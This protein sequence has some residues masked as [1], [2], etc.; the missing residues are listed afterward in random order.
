[1]L[2]DCTSNSQNSCHRRGEAGHAEGPPRLYPTLPASFSFHGVITPYA[3]QTSVQPGTLGLTPPLS[4]YCLS[5]HTSQRRAKATFSESR[6]NFTESR[7]TLS[8][9]FN[10]IK[11]FPAYTRYFGGEPRINKEKSGKTHTC[12][13]TYTLIYTQQRVIKNALVTRSLTSTGQPSGEFTS[14]TSA[15]RKKVILYAMYFYHY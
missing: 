12:L 7:E 9:A 3:T 2:R 1:M 6:E 4:R 10:E 15:Q 14:F 5:E 11:I 8:H 13:Q